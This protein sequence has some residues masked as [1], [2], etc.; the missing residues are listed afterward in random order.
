M[1]LSRR[2]QGINEKNFTGS[3]NCDK[4]SLIQSANCG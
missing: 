3:I 2:A 1:I 4:F